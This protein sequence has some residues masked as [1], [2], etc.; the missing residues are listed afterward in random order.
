MKVLVQTN[1]DNDRQLHMQACRHI[2]RNDIV[3]TTSHSSQA[4]WT[5]KKLIE[6]LR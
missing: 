2:Y 6:I 4:G 5:K 3:T 1:P